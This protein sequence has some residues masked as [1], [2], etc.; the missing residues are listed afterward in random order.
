LE[1]FKRECIFLWGIMSRG[2]LLSQGFCSL[3]YSKSVAY[4]AEIKISM[5][6]RKIGK[7]PWIIPVSMI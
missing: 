5:M 4:S 6:K 3:C 7:S 1:R 2:V